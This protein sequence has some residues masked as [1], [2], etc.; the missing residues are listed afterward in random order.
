MRVAF[1]LHDIG[2]PA[3]IQEGDKNRQ[4]EFTEPIIR[5][6][7]N[8]LRYTDQE[9][10][11]VIAM[12]AGYPIGECIT[13]GIIEE[14]V[15]DIKKKA[16]RINVSAEQFLK[17]L[18]IF[19]KSDAGSYTVDAGGTQALDD[20]FDFDREGHQVQLKEQYQQIIDDL[21]SAVLTN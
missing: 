6:T 1:T 14:D 11:L 15:E 7:M 10:E 20:L 9:R 13:A 3:V 17:L 18:T 21:R 16:S 19:Y 8:Q 4:H 2:K 5:R 12:V